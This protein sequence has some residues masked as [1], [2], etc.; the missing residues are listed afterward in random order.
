MLHTPENL[1]GGKHF[2]Q[3]GE[4]QKALENISCILNKAL[5]EI[6]G[7]KKWVRGCGYSSE[8]ECLPSTL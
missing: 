2:V 7:L 3:F 6:L 1:R 8:G 4:I 5:K